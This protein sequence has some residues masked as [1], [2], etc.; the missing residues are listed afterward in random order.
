MCQQLIELGYTKKKCVKCGNEF[1]SIN[2]RETCGDAPCDEYSF[3]GNPATTENYDLY[4]I[5]EKFR[6]FFQEHGHTPIN[7]YPVLAKRWRD[8]VFLVG[9]SI[10]DFQPWV[11]SG[12][13]EP[14]ANPLTVAQPSI[15]LN[16]VDNV[17]RTGRH[18]TCFTMGAHHAFNTDEKPIYWQDETVKY[19]HDFIKSLG[20][21]PEEVTYIE[22]WWQGG[23]NAGPC[24]E[25]CVRG[26]ELAT[27][28]FIQYELLHDGTKKEIPLR[29]VDTGYGLERFAWISQ[30]T[31]TAYEASFGPVIE[32]LKEITKVEV[33]ERILAENA[34]VA[35][36]MDIET[37]ADLRTLRE[38]VAEK[39][40]I[41]VEELLK[42][43]EPMEAIYVIADHTRCLSFMLADGIIPSNV[44]EGYLARL[45]LRRTIRFMKELN[46]K[47]SL[48]D[49]MKIQSDFLSQTY[50]EIK[51]AQEHILN[52]IELE[53][54]RYEKTISKGKSTVKKTIK[55]LKKQNKT[56]IPLETLIS[57][58]DA[59]GMPPESVKEIAET[60]GFTTNIP[61]N[62]FTIVADSHETEE[63]VE[64]E[65]ID[66][67]YPET[68]LVFYDDPYLKEYDSKLIGIYDDSL[69]F[70]KTVFY[71]EG[72]G[73]PS[74]IGTVTINDTEL[75][76]KH[77]EK[78][79][80]I[81]L[82]KIK[83]PE[84]DNGDLLKILKANIGV[85]VHAKINWERRI[86]LARNHTATHLIVAAARKLLGDHIWQAGAQKGVKRSRIDLAH[87]KRISPEEINE[88][89]KLANTYVR[90][91]FQ[92]DINWMNRTAAEKKHGFIL[93]QGGIVPG[94]NIRV[95]E[96]PEI[97]VQAC[98]GTHVAYTGEIGLIKINKT[99]RVQDGVERI[100]FSAGAAAIE[101]MQTNDKYLKDSS[102][103]FKVNT[104]QLPKTSNRFFTEW[105][106]YKNE[107]NRLKS[108]IADLKIVSLA[109]NII[110]IKVNDTVLK[111]LNE[112]LDSDMKELQKIATDFTDNDKADL[113]VL[114][115]ND[116]KIV[117]AASKRAID[118]G[119]LIN[120]IIREAAALLG[121][122]GGGRPNLAQGA[123]PQSDKIDEALNKTLELIKGE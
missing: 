20:I 11:S 115:N 23:G 119:V 30:G 89:E 113:I 114:G 15:R 103:I 67:D 32:K 85:T 108:Q 91:N 10:F 109:D 72:G 120:N 17:G 6:E 82:H 43:A 107:I 46:M 61:D 29:I 26:V 58:Y 36:M 13:V 39:L 34:Q 35:G 47:E 44:K 7:R 2:D 54:V 59:Q 106:A 51:Q 37:Y 97:D 4:Q 55:Q 83:L 112:K 116:G 1:W 42:S 105:K 111:V 63:Y 31:P 122:G 92:V 70:D 118:S 25:V 24:Y 95:V 3:I 60:M 56:E 21:A 33:D 76:I 53:E 16:D 75:F 5:Q 79:E 40:N 14:P 117:G 50:P 102:A 45:V 69:I 52:I 77:A 93:Y 96:I 123:G 62:F 71:P 84:D 8:D 64:K 48:A 49:M 12:L 18:L 80:N 73:Q 90:D 87:Y 88:I 66:L 78:I 121:G 101:S 81:V 86:E 74:D 100:D 38:K 57:L 28:V 65:E 99:E 22:G 9:A 104:N 110:E 41:S 98:A 94:S 19:C 68:E 27:L